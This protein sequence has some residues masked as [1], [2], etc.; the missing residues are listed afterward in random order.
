MDETATNPVDWLKFAAAECI[1][2]VDCVDYDLAALDLTRPV[3][4]PDI[5][6]ALARLHR[7]RQVLNAAITAVCTDGD[8]DHYSDGRAIATHLNVGAGARW[9]HH[10]HPEPDHWLNRPHTAGE[11][12]TRNGTRKRV[13]VT[14][15]GHLDA[16]SEF[17]GRDSPSWAID[18]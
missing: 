17:P 11:L 5:E 1:A 2:T 7:V 14:A 6:V 8:I 15:P 4:R 13:I 16:V 18:W 9:V 3:T 12:R 10:W